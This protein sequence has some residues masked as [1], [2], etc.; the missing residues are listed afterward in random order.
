MSYTLEDDDKEIIP[1]ASNETTYSF[2]DDEEEKPRDQV[3]TPDKK[4]SKPW[5]DLSE[6]A[7]VKIGKSIVRGVGTTI[8]DVH[9]ESS[10]GASKG[11]IGDLLGF[12]NEKAEEPSLSKKI[13]ENLPDKNED[14]D[15]AIARA[16][17][18]SAKYVSRP[19]SLIFGIPGA[20]ASATSGLAGQLVEEI[21]GGP[22]WQTLA[23]IVTPSY[24]AIKTVLQNAKEQIPSVA[25]KIGGWFSKAE[26]KSAPAQVE[27][28]MQAIGKDAINRLERETTENAKPFQRGEFNAKEIAND[29]ENVTVNRQLDAISPSAGTKQDFG[30]RLVGSIENSFEEAKKGYDAKYAIVKERA[31][32]IETSSEELIKMNDRLIEEINA[33]ETKPPNYQQVI[34][35]VNDIN[36]DLGKKVQPKAKVQL[37]DAQGN[38]LS[39]AEKVTYEKVPLSKKMD[40]SRR[41]NQIINYDLAEY[42]I[43]DRLKP[44]AKKNNMSIQSDLS[45]VDKGL[46]QLYGEAQ[47]E[48]G[49]TAEKFGRA[50]IAK[51]RKA[52]AT[53][54]AAAVIKS[55]TTLEDLKPILSPQEYAAVERQVL[56]EIQG[57][58]QENATKTL[59]ELSPH[60]SPEARI[61]GE[62]IVQFKD[63]KY[64]TGKWN[65]HANAIMDELQDAFT[66]GKRPENTLKLMQT[67]D[68]YK[69]I[70][71]TL[72]NTPTGK[73]ALSYL[74][75]QYID[76]MVASSLK[77]DGSLDWEKLGN[78][79]NSN[80]TNKIIVRQSLGKKGLVEFEK[81]AEYGRN[82]AENFKRY[83]PSVQGKG[84][85]KTIKGH[86][87]AIALPA[88]GLI[89]GG[90]PLAATG[91][92]V[93]AASKL[94]TFLIRRLLASQKAQAA[95]KQLADPNTWK[96]G[97]AERISQSLLREAASGS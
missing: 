25:K 92:G 97:N 15:G 94:S 2:I 52:E 77:K 7:P 85:L 41:I 56:E 64:F 29:L 66:I 93:V 69:T 4:E 58:G 35:T 22:G 55:P 83:G 65:K 50:S 44:I 57:M 87:T 81:F 19:E 30:N 48:F 32:N 91:A 34:D 8:A 75:K 78:I 84:I 39:K 38:P 28:R 11:S 80:E 86:G 88:I 10:K 6:T 54:K 36:A 90:I 26:V 3:K 24:R 49:E 76:D 45:K 23:E 71:E 9:S 62:N 63:P 89:S 60:L 27:Q 31:P 21:G 43:K 20:V 33:L 73:K 67:R 5:Y 82:I 17:E 53:E 12:R 47:K 14:D 79:M 18:R 96:N 37:I 68:G 61:A 46:G 70:Y 16:V 95:F 74:Q 51:L 59:K 1:E 13:R 42:N 40:L 72:H